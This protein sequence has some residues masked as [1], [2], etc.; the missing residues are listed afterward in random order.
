MDNLFITSPSQCIDYKNC[1]G[2]GATVG[3]LVQI[4]LSYPVV[5]VITLVLLYYKYFALR[6]QA[7]RMNVETLRLGVVDDEENAEH[8]IA[9][10]AITNVLLW[11]CI[12]TPYA[13]VSALPVLGLQSSLTPLVCQLPSFL[14]N[15]TQNIYIK[16]S[17]AS[18]IKRVIFALQKVPKR[19][20]F[21]I[22]KSCQKL[23][24]LLCKTVPQR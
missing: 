21:L 3:N 5:D 19:C 6:A 17:C 2:R 16:R 15:N 4:I 12:W 23:L 10:V 14:G 13:S 11:F 20:Y 22:L 8:K 1:E 9:K 7:K 24:F 18:H